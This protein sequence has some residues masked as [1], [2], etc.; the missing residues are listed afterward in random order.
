VQIIFYERFYQWEIMSGG[1]LAR[2]TNWTHKFLT[3]WMKYKND[4]LAKFNAD[5]GPLH[6][7][8][9]RTLMPNASHVIK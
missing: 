5:N 8:L 9:L 3:D 4:F 7:H 2:N 1:M 6:M